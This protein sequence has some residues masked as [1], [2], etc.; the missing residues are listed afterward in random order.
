M[1]TLPYRDPLL[2][3]LGKR[4]DV[5]RRR[6][7]VVIATL[8]PELFLRIPP[9]GG[10]SVGEVFE[11]MCVANASYTL[12]IERAIAKALT[13]SGAPRAHRHTLGGSFLIRALGPGNRRLPSPKPYRPLEPR[14]GVV[15]AFLASLDTCESL[16]HEADGH[17]LR[18][19]LASPVMPLLRMNLGEAF[20]VGVVHS[21]RHLVQI[22]RTRKVV[23]ADA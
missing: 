16:M 17:D 14:D 20:E 3:S 21:E 12:P 5:L 6:T 7:G 4:I 22:E 1:T 18:V 13:R 9:G 23:E 11:H 2:A 15:G 19:M 10:W 8:R